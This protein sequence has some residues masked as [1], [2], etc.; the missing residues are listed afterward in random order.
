MSAL[1]DILHRDCD[2]EGAALAQAADEAQARDQF[3]R[4]LPDAAT[5]HYQLQAARAELDRFLGNML[6]PKAGH[7]LARVPWLD[8]WTVVEYRYEPPEPQ[9]E[10]EPAVPAEIEI[11]RVLINGRMC[12]AHDAASEYVLDQ[13][14]A[15]LYA[16]KEHSGVLA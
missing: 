7:Y 5:L 1:L 15:D 8:S 13:W 9:S 2:A 4:T 6:L 10:W 14:H 12:W 16:R 11:V 3:R